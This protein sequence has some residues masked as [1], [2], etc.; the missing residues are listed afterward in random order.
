MPVLQVSKSAGALAKLHGLALRAWEEDG[1][2]RVEGFCVRLPIGAAVGFAHCLEKS[3]L[4]TTVETDLALVA[5]FGLESIIGSV[6]ELFV[7]SQSDVTWRQQAKN[8]VDR[9]ADA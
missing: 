3:E 4:G 8:I 2:G 6:V 1:L 5:E 7:L 9:R